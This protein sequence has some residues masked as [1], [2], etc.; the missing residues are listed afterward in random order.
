MSNKHVLTNSKKFFVVT[1][2]PRAHVQVDIS[3]NDR[4]QYL[5]HDILQCQ[6]SYNKQ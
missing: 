2:R 4:Y 3:D 5:E 1:Y 6:H